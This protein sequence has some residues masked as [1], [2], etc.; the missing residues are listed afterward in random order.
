MPKSKIET[1]RLRRVTAR[2]GEG[3]V[4]GVLKIGAVRYLPRGVKKED[5]ARFG[6]FDIWLAQLAPSREL[7]K[8]YKAAA[9]GDKAWKSFEAAYRKEVNAS[10]ETKQLIKFIAIVSAATAVAVGCYCEDVSRCHR[11]ILKDLI[12]AAFDI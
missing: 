10:T 2:L 12:D 5:Y 1:Y 3:G 6:Y 11:S 4:A 7:V 8:Q 9:D